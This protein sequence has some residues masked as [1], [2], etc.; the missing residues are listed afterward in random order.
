MPAVCMCCGVCRESRCRSGLKAVGVGV[1]ECVC[2]CWRRHL[3]DLLRLDA[4]QSCWN[5]KH[6]VAVDLF[7]RFFQ[8]SQNLRPEPFLVADGQI[9]GSSE[10]KIIL[11]EISTHALSTTPHAAVQTYNNPFNTTEIEGLRNV[12]AVVCLSSTRWC[13]RVHTL[14]LT[15]QSRLPARILDILHSSDNFERK[16]LRHSTMFLRPRHASTAAVSST[17]AVDNGHPA[18]SAS[19]EEEVGGVL[20]PATAETKRRQRSILRQIRFLRQNLKLHLS[21]VT[22]SR[23][24][25]ML[26]ICGGWCLLSMC[27]VLLFALLRTIAMARVGSSAGFLDDGGEMFT[28]LVNT[29]ERPRHLEE[30]VRHYAKCEGYVWQDIACSRYTIPCCRSYPKQY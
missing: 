4:T 3:H 16:R 30:A 22:R 23:R 14:Q 24:K 19:I 11:R 13:G 17:T 25:A 8:I 10:G 27:T 12:T 9:S 1:C 5:K 7:H 2:G 18:P 6:F 15:A 20:P 21:G 28:V 29:F 26:A